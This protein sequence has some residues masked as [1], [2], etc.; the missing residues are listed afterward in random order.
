[1]IG[2]YRSTSREARPQRG[3][4]PDFCAAAVLLLAWMLTV[5]PALVAPPPPAAAQAFSG[6]IRDT[7]I[8][9]AIR[10]LSTPVLRAARLDP[11]SVRLRLIA[12]ANIQ[13]V[14][15][16]GQAIY[17]YTGLLLEADEVGAVLGVLAH[18]AGHIAGGHLVRGRD[19]LAAAR[20]QSAGMTLLGIAAAL[21]GSAD[22]GVALAL[23]GQ[24]SAQNSLFSF[25]R[26]QEQLAD[27]SA[28]D[29]ME[30]AGISAVP[31]L[32]FLEMLEDQELLP[33]SQQT[34][35][36]RTHPVTGERVAQVRR[37][38]DTSRFNNAPPP[39]SFTAL[40][41]RVQAK[42]NG[43]LYPRQVLRRAVPANPSFA[44]RYAHA[45][46]LY[47]RGE[48]AE[49][50]MRLEALI[51]AQ[52][53]DPYL[54]E[55]K[56]Q[57][58]FENSRVAEA[59]PAYAR[60]LELDPGADLIRVAHAHALIESNEPAQL[61]PARS[62]LV[63]AIAAGE[64]TPFAWRLLATA[65]GRLGNEIGAALALA[66][67]AIRIGDLVTARQQAAKVI[68]REPEGTRAWLRARDIEAAAD[69]RSER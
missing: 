56:G 44:D 48:V 12:D 41:A 51:T 57:I 4:R 7:E 38:L 53:D 31:Y 13:A 33:A 39:P 8:E 28:L 24:F 16:G 42:L 62:A 30:K 47:R 64:A 26:R 6:G 10:I 63:R 43:F 21:A 67:E 58:L 46:A 27:Q 18:E 66:E 5:I 36:A 35:F 49:A 2:F 1:M 54:H 61:S 60:A 11:E 50:L 20:R 23:G 52:P 19:A 68:G 14:V 15:T 17:L 45:I 9:R 25:S 69:R 22:A 3:Y 55:L 32:H 59:I 40:F 34:S 37:H 29:Y 65:E